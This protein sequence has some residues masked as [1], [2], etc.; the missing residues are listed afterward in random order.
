MFLNHLDIHFLD[1]QMAF[2]KFAIEIIKVFLV[3]YPNTDNNT[4]EKKMQNL[5]KKKYNPE[6]QKSR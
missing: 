2:R 3:R 4:I 6:L 5:N 1:I